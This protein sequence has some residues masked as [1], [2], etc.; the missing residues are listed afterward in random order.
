MADNPPEVVLQCG[1]F[2]FFLEKIILTLG[3][4]YST[5]FAQAA[6]LQGVE[7]I[8]GPYYDMIHGLFEKNKL[9]A[10]VP[11]NSNPYVNTNSVKPVL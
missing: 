9:A 8:E 10:K 2:W 1:L 5:D 7:G 6:A 4:I 11:T 3:K